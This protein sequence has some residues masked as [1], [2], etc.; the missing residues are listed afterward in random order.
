MRL[1]SGWRLNLSNRKITITK[2]LTLRSKYN[3][4]NQYR[5]LPEL[6]GLI[7]N[8][9]IKCRFLY[10]IIWLYLWSKLCNVIYQT[11]KRWQLF[12]FYIYIWDRFNYIFLM[13]IYCCIARRIQLN[14]ISDKTELIKNTS[15]I[16]LFLCWFEQ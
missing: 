11:S 8:F 7:Q 6:F 1:S 3:S 15:R 9:I 14:N 5:Y 16:L 10:S 4:I 13:P 2:Y 12:F